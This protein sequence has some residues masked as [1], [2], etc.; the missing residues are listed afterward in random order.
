MLAEFNK[1]LLAATDGHGELTKIGQIYK[2]VINPTAT[3]TICFVA[4]LHGNEQ[5]GT[6]GALEFI[7]SKSYISETKKVII[8][9]LANPDGF[10]KNTRE[11]AKGKDINRHFLEPELKDE[12][13]LVWECIK[14]DNVE[15]LHTLHEDP[16]MES[17]YCYYTHH[18]QLAESLRNLAEKYFQIYGGT[19]DLYGDK[20][21]NGLIPLPHDVSGTIEDK[22]LL[23][24]AIPYVTTES[25]GK[26]PLGLRADFN[27]NAIKMTI[28]YFV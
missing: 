10:S 11:N 26:L 3:R 16:D 19:G 14:D 9:P 20:I 12:C 5:G 27:K 25:P 28:D 6:Y 2:F 18:K 22:F 8:I 17:F 21:Y 24:C 4:G 15:M 1:E 7:K 13:K 23:H